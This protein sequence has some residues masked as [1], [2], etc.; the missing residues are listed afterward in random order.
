MSTEIKPL[1]EFQTSTLLKKAAVACDVNG[2]ESTYCFGKFNEDI[3]IMMIYAPL[4]RGKSGP[5]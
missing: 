5:S 2:S 4:E 1:M 3:Y